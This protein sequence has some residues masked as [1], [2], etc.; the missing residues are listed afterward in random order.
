[1]CILVTMVRYFEELLMGYINFLVGQF[2]TILLDTIGLREV[3]MKNPVDRFDIERIYRLYEAQDYENCLKLVKKVSERLGATTGWM[4][5]VSGICEDMLGNP[6]NGLQHFKNAVASDPCNHTFLNS[7]CANTNIFRS[8][9]IDYLE[10]QG[11]LEDVEKI[12][13]ALL[14]AGELN[15]TIQY[16]LIKNYIHRDQVK[17][18]R[19]MLGIYLMNNPNDD[20]AL[21]LEKMVEAS[22]GPRMVS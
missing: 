10:G 21:A 6:F 7:L 11:T 13:K 2:L 9:L 3:N 4:H 8:M 18:A 5:W 22:I 1:M 16:L 15:S 20:E 19:D 12:H 14:L 17:T